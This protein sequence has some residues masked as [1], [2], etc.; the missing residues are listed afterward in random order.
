VSIYVI[1]W[2]IVGSLAAIATAFGLAYA[3][4]L[5][6]RFL[7]HTYDHGGPAHLMI[8]AE[9]LRD[10]DPEGGRTVVIGHNDLQWCRCGDGNVAQHPPRTPTNDHEFPQLR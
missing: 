4:R 5:H 6:Y 8:A 2:M 3:C 9:A 10:S 1:V 7:Q